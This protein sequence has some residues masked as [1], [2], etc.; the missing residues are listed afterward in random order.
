MKAS[1]LLV[2]EK[3]GGMAL[4]GRCISSQF[5]EE[6]KHENFVLLV[7]EA[8]EVVKFIMDWRNKS[9]FRSLISWPDSEYDS[10][11]IYFFPSPSLRQ[12]VGMNWSSSLKVRGDNL[13]LFPE[14]LQDEMKKVFAELRF[15][16]HFRKRQL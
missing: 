12:S 15:G 14:L 9:L 2:S 1:L 6:W 5:S 11:G 3:S 10:F 13:H 7:P 8:I 4:R 16:V